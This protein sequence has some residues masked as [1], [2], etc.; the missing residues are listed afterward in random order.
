MAV[1]DGLCFEDRHDNSGTVLTWDAWC[2]ILVRG[3]I[4]FEREVVI[5]RSLS[6][7]LPSE[8]CSY[9]ALCMVHVAF[10]TLPM[11]ENDG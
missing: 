3:S 1:E 9:A 10:A 8:T 2:E 6:L 5:L 11:T 4:S 7:C